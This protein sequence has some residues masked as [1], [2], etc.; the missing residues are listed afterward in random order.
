[1]LAA[2]K[3]FTGCSP[4]LARISSKLDTPSW[5]STLEMI[6]MYWPLGPST[7]RRK[8]HEQV[9]SAL[10]SAR[11]GEEPEGGQRLLAALGAQHLHRQ[12]AARQSLPKPCAA[13]LSSR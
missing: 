4:D 10:Q 3:L 1:M 8:E 7:C 12:L 13:L 11:V 2:T 6:L 9:R 5:F